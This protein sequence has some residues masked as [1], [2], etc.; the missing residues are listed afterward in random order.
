M[1]S[2]VR[3]YEPFEALHLDWYLSAA[4]GPQDQTYAVTSYPLISHWN[5]HA[6]TQAHE[7]APLEFD[8]YYYVQAASPALLRVC[9]QVLTPLNEAGPIAKGVNTALTPPA[10]GTKRGHTE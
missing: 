5:N 9:K 6:E 2:G 8:H 7:G 1:K 3:V 10:T 4:K